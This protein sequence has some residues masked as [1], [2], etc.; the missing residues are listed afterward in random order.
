V[1]TFNHY[2][3]DP[4]MT[5]D[6][7]C[8]LNAT[9]PGTPTNVVA[10]FSGNVVTVS[11]DSPADTGKYPILYYTV[12]S[13]PSGAIA[14]GFS[15]LTFTGLELGTTYTFIVVATNSI[16]TSVPSTPS[17][18]VVVANVPN[19]PSILVVSSG[20]EE[21]AL[22]WAPNGD[23]GS[24]ILNY[25]VTCSD[26]IAPV[27][28]TETS[29]TITGLTNGTS[30]TF[31]VVATNAIGD[32]ESSTGSSG[33]PTASP[34]TLSFTANGLWVAPA[35][36]V[37][38]VSYLLVGGGGGGGASYDNQGAGGGA[39]GQFLQGTDSSIVP[40]QVYNVIVG[41][42]G[43]GGIGQRDVAPPD[44]PGLPGGSSTFATITA[45]GGGGGF[46]SRTTGSGELC[47][48]GTGIIGGNG[49][50]TPGSRGGGGGGGSYA[51]G[52]TGANASGTSGGV[53]GNGTLIGDS[54]E[55]DPTYGTG[56]RGGNSGTNNYGGIPWFRSVSTDDP[57]YIPP[58]ILPAN[59]GNG[60]AGAGATSNSSVYGQA[61]ADGFVQITY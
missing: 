36:S 32:S 60:G 11:W 45:S 5:D 21:I 56:G 53:G 54:I 58:Q 41:L 59:S 2:D 29:T 19:A 40:N 8:P 23:G 51:G 20:H 14:T 43:A 44:N 24:A 10:D 49:G 37:S 31:T 4:V 12:Y 22:A 27:T 9:L 38:S 33:T 57:Q 1:Y 16:G 17:A 52:S 25:T 30:Y 42:G 35:N 15:P 48:G 28:T 34:I 6:G 55:E 47:E 61:G 7:C 13:D 26:G 39:G 50:G 46:K 18:S 3:V